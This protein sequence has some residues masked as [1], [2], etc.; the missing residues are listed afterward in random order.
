M[1][2]RPRGCGGAGAGRTT[3]AG[4]AFCGGRGVDVGAAAAGG[5]SL[6]DSAT[7]WPAFCWVDACRR[8]RRLH[9][10]CLVT[11]TLRGLPAT[12]HRRRPRL[13]PR[14]RRPR[15]PRPVP[16]TPM[17]PS[18]ARGCRPA[19]PAVAATCTPA[20][21]SGE[22]EPA[23]DAST[24]AVAVV[25]DHAVATAA[26]AAARTA[27][28][29]ARIPARR[30]RGNEPADSPTGSVPDVGEASGGSANTCAHEPGGRAGRRADSGRPRRRRGKRRRHRHKP[31]GRRRGRRSLRGLAAPCRRWRAGARSGPLA[32]RHGKLSAARR[33]RQDGTRHQRRRKR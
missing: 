13:L 32:S 24:A 30:S 15:R 17:L 33:C 18:P 10:V 11:P 27:A 14:H 31:W 1:Q 12:G 21:R 26:V 2:L 20:S 3:L 6:P 19:A 16:P 23:A 25:S 28:A 22:E 4:A 29:A 8:R 7:R 5:G 9:S